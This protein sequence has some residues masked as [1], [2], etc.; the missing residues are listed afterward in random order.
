MLLIGTRL[1]AANPKIPGEISLDP[2]NFATLGRRISR[3]TARSLRQ[4]ASLAPRRAAVSDFSC[5][6]C[7]NRVDYWRPYGNGLSDLSPAMLR[8][9]V[10][11][12]NVERYR[13]PHCGSNDRERHLRLYF[14]RLGLWNVFAEAKVLHIAPERKLSDVINAA[15]PALYIRGD[16]Y[17]KEETI[18][19][20]DL[21]NVKFPNE[22]FDFVICNHV[23]EHVADLSTVLSEVHRVLRGP[24]GGLFVRPLMPRGSPGRSRNRSC[25]ARLTADFSTVKR[26]MCGFSDS[27]SSRRFGKLASKAG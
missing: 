10:V 14:D 11:G 26:T 4:L 12:S 16:L 23:L 5:V 21:E 27:T 6:Y 17:P 2:T 7:K 22:T 13:C 15:G 25:R 18:Q 9:Q 24:E 1:K 20:V 3:K 8:L 19:E